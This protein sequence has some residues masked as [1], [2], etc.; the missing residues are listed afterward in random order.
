[1]R[2][3]PE[4]RQI[5]RHATSVRLM[6]LACLLSAVEAAL[7]YLPLP[8][9]HGVFAGLAAVLSIAAPAARVIAQQSLQSIRF[10]GTEEVDDADKS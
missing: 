6:L 10:T 4:W 3:L 2:L 1:M 8:M 9:P 7:P 5:L